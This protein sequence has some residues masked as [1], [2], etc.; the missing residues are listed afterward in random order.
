LEKE[1]IQGTTP[2]ARARARRKRAGWALQHHILNRANNGGI[3]KDGG[4]ETTVED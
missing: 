4:R 3:V 1:I 2:A